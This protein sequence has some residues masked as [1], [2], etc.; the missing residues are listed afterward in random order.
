VETGGYSYTDTITKF[1]NPTVL[2]SDDMEGS[3]VATKWTVSSGWNYSTDDK[4]AG[5]KAL[6]ESPG[7]D[8]TTSANQTATY[9]GS[10]DLTNATAAYLSFWVKHRAENFRDKLQVQVSANG[11]TWVPISGS[12]TVQEPGMLDGNTINGEPSLTGIREDWTAEVFD[13]TAYKGTA[14][15]KL[16]F[17]F[18]SDADGGSFTYEKDDG[19]YIDNLKVVKSSSPLVILPVR[20]ISFYGKVLN[21]QS[22]QLS[23]EA[24][25]DEHH[26]HFE[27]EHSLNGIYFKSIGNVATM[28]PY[29][30]I[31]K[32]PVIGSNFYRIK[33]TAKDGK[34]FYSKVIHLSVQ[35]SFTV[36]MFPNPTSNTIRIH[37]AN[38][39]PETIKV[40]VSDLQGRIIYSQDNV[41]EEA[42]NELSIDT[43]KWKPQLYVLKILNRQNVVLSIQKIT[44]M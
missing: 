12:T 14:A 20:F 41:K 15:L 26:D 18:T 28:P 38:K 21:N 27:I 42:E 6:T 36:T 7:G 9:N 43:D 1:Y 33:Q 22:T 4:Y 17:A 24:I 31:D 19:F 39:Y 30:F 34:S 5:T 44:K 23:W 16:R 32:H 13:L 40:Q 10:L 2:L 11:T 8:Y 3:S 35:N 37:W 25:T 29:Q